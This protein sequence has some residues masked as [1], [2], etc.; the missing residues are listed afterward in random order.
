MIETYGLR[1]E[2]GGVR[3][4][5][6]VADSLD[7]SQQE[8]LGKLGYNN[9]TEGDARKLRERMKKQSRR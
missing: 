6:G 4:H 1:V 9:R 5:V 3:T 7:R 8:L 2:P